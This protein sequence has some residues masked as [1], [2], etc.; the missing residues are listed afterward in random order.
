MHREMWGRWENYPWLYVHILLLSQLCDVGLA[1]RPSTY[2][3]TRIARG[4]SSIYKDATHHT[5]SVFRRKSDLMMKSS[6]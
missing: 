2:H 3:N 4:H 1:W 5:K 6:T